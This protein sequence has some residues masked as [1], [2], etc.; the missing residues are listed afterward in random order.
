[1]AVLGGSKKECRPINPKRLT[2][3]VVSAGLDS[4]S[5]RGESQTRFPLPHNLRFR[6]NPKRFPDILVFDVIPSDFTRREICGDHEND[7]VSSPLF[8]WTEYVKS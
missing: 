1:M 2:S 7:H 3:R 6:S 5:R 4:R 8:V